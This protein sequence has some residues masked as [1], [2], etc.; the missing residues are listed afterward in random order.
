ME[1]NIIVKNVI[2]NWQ[3]QSE[4]FQKVLS[5]LSNEQLIKDVAPGKNSGLYILG[6]VIA[7][8]E[9]ITPLLNLG[10]KKYPELENF[11]V[12]SP[13][14]LGQEMFE[15]ETLR[16]I[17]R[18]TA[19]SLTEHFLNVETDEWLERH[20]A[21]SAEDFIK[22]PHRNK[23]SVLLSRTWHQSYHLGQLVLLK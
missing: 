22:E 2:T 4:Y 12:H 8:N 13:D 6:H 5:G 14:K 11:F 17:W 18:E 19:N 23:L 15:P 3:K 10:E 7:V 16:N 21:V 1:N 9:N 20:T